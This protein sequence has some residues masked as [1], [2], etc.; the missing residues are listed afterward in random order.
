M[1]AIPPRTLALA[2]QAIAETNPVLD[3]LIAAVPGYRRKYP[4]RNLAILAIEVDLYRNA[5]R[6]EAPEEGLAGLLAIAL[7]RLAEAAS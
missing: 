2:D 3:E 4:D 1:S 6:W 5:T 7:V